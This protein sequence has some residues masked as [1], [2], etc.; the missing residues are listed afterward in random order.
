MPDKYSLD[1]EE[2]VQLK[3][4]G[5]AKARVGWVAFALLLITVLVVMVLKDALQFVIVGDCLEVRFVNLPGGERIGTMAGC[6]G[7]VGG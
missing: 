1:S 7:E 2:K 6:R 5:D 4:E 3:R